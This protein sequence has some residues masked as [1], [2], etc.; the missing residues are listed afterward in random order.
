MDRVSRSIATVTFP[1]RESRSRNQ[2]TVSRNETRPFRIE[3]SRRKRERTVFDSN[4]HILGPSVTFTK[5]SDASA[6]DRSRPSIPI[7]KFTTQ[8]RRAHSR[9][10]VFDGKGG[11]GIPEDPFTIHGPPAGTKPRGRIMRTSESGG[12]ACEWVKNPRA[13]APKTSRPPAPPPRT[14]PDPCTS[15]GPRGARRRSPAAC[16]TP[17]RPR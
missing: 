10:A 16:N 5:P 7:R 2:A 9:S 13:S 17:W 14:R 15:R 8:K 12:V 11:N 3:T 1:A 6:I 4:R